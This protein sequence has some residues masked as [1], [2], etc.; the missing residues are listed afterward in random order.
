MKRLFTGPLMLAAALTLT[1]TIAL[2]AQAERL[3]FVPSEADG[4][5][6]VVNLRTE[7]VEKTLPTGKVPH[8]MAIAPGGKIF[9]NNRGS[10]ELTII[11]GMAVEVAGA[12]AL[13]ATSFQLGMSPNGKTLA[14]AYKDALKLSLVDAATNAVTKTIDVGKLPEGEF[15]GVMM[16]HP[17]WTP[18]GRF[19]YVADAVNKVIVKVDVAQGKVDKII[20]IDGINHYLHPSPDGKLLYLVNEKRGGGTS[21]TLIDPTTDQIVK[22]LPVSLNADEKGLGHHGVFTKDG[23]YFLF[24]NEG[25]N[26]VTVLD[27]AKKEW[28]KTIP[29]G[30][31]PGHAAL[32]PDGKHFFVIH[33]N[34]GVLTVID[35]AKLEAVKTIK[36]GDGNKQAHGFWFSPDG[37][38][39]YAVASADGALVKVD[40]AKQEVT[41][42]MAVGPNSFFFAV[43]DG[44]TFSAYE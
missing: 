26:R 11:N 37:K 28:V 21:L 22:D 44:N 32:T 19:V 10:K 43:K 34:D 31:G 12:I 8:A 40:V 5:V 24:C 29:T 7:K 25:G 33:H 42:R 15:K 23:R 35:A 20:N 13:P 17:Y 38:Y 30:K 36:I 18:D 41:S 16:K 3:A 2:A 39:F 1:S 9:V 4:N 27:T 6:M 14:V